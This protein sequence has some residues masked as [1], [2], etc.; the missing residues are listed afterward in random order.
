MQYHL[1]IRIN[2]KG[3]IQIYPPMLAVKKKHIYVQIPSDEPVDNG[4]YILIFLFIIYI[5]MHIRKYMK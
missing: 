4:V 3:L 5:Y 2:L 1:S